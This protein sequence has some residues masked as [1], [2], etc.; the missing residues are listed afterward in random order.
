MFL[1]FRKTEIGQSAVN[2]VNSIHR[3]LQPRQLTFYAGNIP[4]SIGGVRVG[5]ENET[6]GRFRHNIV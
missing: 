3:K 1:K 6:R 5:I 2:V 4:H